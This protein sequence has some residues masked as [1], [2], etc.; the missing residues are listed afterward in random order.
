MGALNLCG[1]KIMVREY[2]TVNAEN[3]IDYLKNLEIY[4][5]M[6]SRVGKRSVNGSECRHP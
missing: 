6:N 4:T 3:M 2:E 5:Q 1:M